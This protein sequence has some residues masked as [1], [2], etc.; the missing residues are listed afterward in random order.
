MVK[1]LENVH[2]LSA[3][4]S[5]W[6]HKLAHCAPQPCSLPKAREGHAAGLIGNK[7]WI[8][9][10]VG[11][12]GRGYVSLTDLAYLDTKTFTW[13]DP[14]VQMQARELAPSGRS[15]AAAV[16]LGARLL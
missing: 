13:H 15:L 3:D 11:R 2:V 1:I 7:L 16:T 8:F 12:V 14:Q 6:E 5:V 9:G 10:G 4:G